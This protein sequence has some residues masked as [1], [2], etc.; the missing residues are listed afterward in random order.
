MH[1]NDRE[2]VKTVYAGEIAAAVGLKDTV[3]SDTLCDE[4]NPVILEK[5]VVPEPVISMRIEPKTKADQEKLGLA[6]SKLATEDPT[7]RV[8]SDPETNETLIAGMGEL[9][10]DII[11]DR[12]KENSM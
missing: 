4:G 7:F 11:V 12:L 5:I 8:S 3:T 2:E 9:H 1:S 10:L 6:L